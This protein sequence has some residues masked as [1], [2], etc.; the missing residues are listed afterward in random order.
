M[1][2]HEGEE[3]TGIRTA[4]RGKETGGDT[5]LKA[6]RKRGEEILDR[7]SAATAEL[8]PGAL[9]GLYGYYNPC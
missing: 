8:V 2:Q 1:K 5:R 9:S 6:R 3:D 4:G 7:E